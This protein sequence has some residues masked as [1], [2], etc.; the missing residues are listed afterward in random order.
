MKHVYVVSHKRIMSKEADDA[1]LDD[2]IEKYPERCI[3]VNPKGSL[4]HKLLYD[5]KG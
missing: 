2:F 4:L 3:T 5:K 1:F